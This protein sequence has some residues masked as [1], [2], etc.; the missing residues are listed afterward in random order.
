MVLPGGLVTHAKEVWV[1]RA[2]GRPVTESKLAAAR[3]A[4]KLKDA[5]ITERVNAERRK[6]EQ[7]PPTT[8]R[9]ADPGSLNIPLVMG[10]SGP[11]E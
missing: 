2:D 3:V 6:R 11:V 10:G 1:L 7:L 4:E 9:H 8:F 5:E